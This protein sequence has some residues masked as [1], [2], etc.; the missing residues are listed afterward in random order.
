[1]FAGEIQELKDR[2]AAEAAQAQELLTVLLPVRRALIERM[3][4]F[5]K[6]ALAAGLA[7]YGPLQIKAYTPHN[8][9]CSILLNHLPLVILS[10]DDV[11]HMPFDEAAQRY[12]ALTGRILVYVSGAGDGLPLVEIDIAPTARGGYQCLLSLRPL[13]GGAQDYSEKLPLAPSDA[14]C[15]VA[16]ANRVIRYLVDLFP[17]WPAHPALDWMHAP[18]GV[19]PLALG[20][21]P[22]PAA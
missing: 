22:R 8:L 12:G 21:T 6:E 20:F 16:V 4:A 15:G 17:L 7:G 11:L 14:D 1:V 19:R 18:A 9:E 3:Q 2:Q 5:A 10:T 13:A